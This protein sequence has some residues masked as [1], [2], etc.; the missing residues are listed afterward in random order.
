MAQ[1]VRNSTQAPTDQRPQHIRDVIEGSAVQL[2]VG[3]GRIENWL[4]FGQGNLQGAYQSYIDAFRLLV[5]LTSSLQEIKSED[6]VVK[7]AVTFLES[8]TD[9]G[10]WERGSDQPRRA[11]VKKAIVIS[12]K[13]LRFI[14]TK[15][16]IAVNK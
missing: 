6:Q 15:G 8:S 7:E 10:L 4:E 13:F 9:P 1:E 14:G 3:T 16:L 11:H 12:D 5:R 2:A